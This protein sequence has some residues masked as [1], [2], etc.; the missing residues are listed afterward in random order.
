MSS[1]NAV[2]KHD[3]GLVFGGVL[4]V[5]C[6]FV[7]LFWPGLTLVTLAIL[8]GFLFLFAG[9]ADLATFFGLRKDKKGTGWILV[10]AIL[11]II[12]GFMF[13]LHPLAA[14][15]VLPWVVGCFVIAYGVVAIASSF[16]FRSYGSMWILMLINGILSVIIGIL[17]VMD[18]ATF[19]LF[20]GFFV[21]W[22]GIVMAISGIVAPRNLPY[23]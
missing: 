13:L 23:M 14:A 20:L 7:I 21:I 1:N 22:R 12:L 17:F 9:G 2:K 5:I 4:L 15:E 18:P 16:G 11:D 10:N 3:W 6:A 8:A 19:V